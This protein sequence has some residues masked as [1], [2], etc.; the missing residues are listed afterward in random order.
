MEKSGKKVRSGI[1][2]CFPVGLL[3]VGVAAPLSGQV[4]AAVQVSASVLSTGPSA[5]GLRMAVASL[6]LPPKVRTT[7][8]A[9]VSIRGRTDLLRGR[10]DHPSQGRTEYPKPTEI[11]EIHFLRN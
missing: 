8:L 2:L 7:R 3:L 11:V 9:T 4:R 6:S 10:A 5:D 1:G